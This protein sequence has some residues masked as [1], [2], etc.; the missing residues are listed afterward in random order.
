VKD[1]YFAVAVGLWAVVSIGALWSVLPSRPPSRC[2]YATRTLA[3]LMP[4]YRSDTITAAELDR[5][6]A[7]TDLKV[8][9]E[10]AAA[11]T[12]PH[13]TLGETP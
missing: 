13:V 9:C 2:D 11:K 5:L 12:R 8:M 7:A 1:K 6:D 3:E 10:R 4:K